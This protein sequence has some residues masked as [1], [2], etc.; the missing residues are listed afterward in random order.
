MRL[1]TVHFRP[2]GLNPEK[3]LVLIKEGFSWLGFF[4]SGFWALA[5]GLWIAAGGLF[6]GS[7][8]LIGILVLIEPTPITELAISLG[9]A[10]LIGFIANDLHRWTLERQDYDLVGVVSGA[11]IDEAEQRFLDNEP[12]KAAA[13]YS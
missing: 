8:V 4:F 10:V 2:Y 3:N 9:Y 5:H 11:G 7:G 1:Y 13:V 6:V 12:E